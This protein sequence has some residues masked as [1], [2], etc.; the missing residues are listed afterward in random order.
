MD[1]LWHLVL[2]ISVMTLGGFAYLS[3][4]MR[5]SMIDNLHQDYTRTAK[6]KGV[7]QF[8]VITKHVLR[9]SLLPMITIFATIIPG[10]LGGSI[11]IEGDFFDSGPGAVGR[12][13]RANSRDLP[14]LQAMTFIGSLLTLIC[15]LVAGYLLR[16]WRIRGC[17]MT[18]MQAQASTNT[19]PGPELPVAA[20]E[21]ASLSYWQV[22]RRAF[23]RR[24]LHSGGGDLM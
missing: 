11:I 24:V 15:F 12:L 18:E 5:A 7:S 1:Y 3:K 9:N 17:R 20:R 2:P 6:A 4:L 21:K 13:R 23:F 19:L 16:G 10:L 8:K 22:V 14:V